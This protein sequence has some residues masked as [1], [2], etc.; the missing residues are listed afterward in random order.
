MPVMEASKTVSKG[1]GKEVYAR[2]LSEK[3]PMGRIAVLP[4]NPQG[5]VTAYCE[6]DDCGIEIHCNPPSAGE[7]MEGICC[8]LECSR[9]AGYTDWLNKRWSA[10]NSRRPMPSAPTK[11]TAVVVEER[12]EHIP[13]DLDDDDVTVT[14]TV[15]PPAPKVTKPAPK[16]VEQ[17]KV[18]KVPSPKVEKSKPVAPKVEKPTPAPKPKEAPK[19]KLPRNL[20]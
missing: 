5:A 11:T 18:E 2:V 4:I 17:P 16:V 12:E 9:L 8:S 15:E 6:N 20:F 13:D 7:R 1:R 14:L 10:A 3:N 19:K